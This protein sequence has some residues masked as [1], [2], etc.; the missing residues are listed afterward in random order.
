M[1]LNPQLAKLCF[2]S[3]G[4]FRQNAIQIN[5]SEVTGSTREEL[6]NYSRLTLNRLQSNLSQTQKKLDKDDLE[7]CGF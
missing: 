6:L 7:M 5:A 3:I 4:R 1:N 2:D